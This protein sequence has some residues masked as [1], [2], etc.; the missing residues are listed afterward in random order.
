M[1]YS[2]AMVNRGYSP[3]EG[4]VESG[5]GAVGVSVTTAG[6]CAQA[7]ASAKRLK[8]DNISRFIGH[9][10]WSMRPTDCVAKRPAARRGLPFYSVRQAFAQSEKRLSRIS[11]LDCHPRLSHSIPL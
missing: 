6:G 5:D 3:P 8:R 4:T 1:A 7:K 2:R 10:S 9:F 11:F